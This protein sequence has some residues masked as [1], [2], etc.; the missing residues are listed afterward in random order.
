M[1]LSQQALKLMERFFLS[2][3]KLVLELLVEI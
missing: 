3:F 2:N 1:D